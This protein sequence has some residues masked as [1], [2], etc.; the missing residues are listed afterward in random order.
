[1]SWSI[2]LHFLFSHLPIP[3]GQMV[4]NWYIIFYVLNTN[5]LK[6][7]LLPCSY[8]YVMSPACGLRLLEAPLSSDTSPE[9]ITT[10]IIPFL[11]EHSAI[12]DPSPWKNHSSFFHIWNQ[13][14]IDNLLHG[15][16]IIISQTQI[17]GLPRMCSSVETA[18]ANT[19]WRK[20]IDDS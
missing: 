13:L 18:G 19:F 16:T 1:M 5:F 9:W 11:E 12:I 4:S 17:S 20:L 2:R 14:W 8:P 10:P 15:E 3:L 7:S 6:R